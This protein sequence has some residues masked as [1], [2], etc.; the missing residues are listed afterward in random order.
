MKHS[1]QYREDGVLNTMEVD[2]MFPG[3]AR[4]VLRLIQR[5]W[6]AQVQY[7][8]TACKLQ[9]VPSYPELHVQH[10]CGAQHNARTG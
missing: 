2:L 10:T 1:L 5:W 6:D 7:M 9:H 8:R 4:S 3:E